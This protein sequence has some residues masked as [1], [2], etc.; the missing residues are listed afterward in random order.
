M[1]GHGSS[2]TGGR[3]SIKAMDDKCKDI[4][5]EALERYFGPR[6]QEI[7]PPEEHVVAL[8]IEEMVN[9]REE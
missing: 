2:I 7:I 9:G 8:M 4:S 3:C 6:W 5:P 1:C